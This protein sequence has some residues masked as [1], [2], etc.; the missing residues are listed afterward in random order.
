VAHA[1]CTR[2]GQQINYAEV[3]VR[4]DAGKTLAQ[5]LVTVSVTGERSD[6]V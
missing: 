6:A 1:Q 4:S 5:G 2:R 3:L